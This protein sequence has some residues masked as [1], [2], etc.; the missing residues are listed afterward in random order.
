MRYLTQI[1]AQARQA[2]RTRIAR[3]LHDTT[4]QG[5]HA[6]LLKLETWAA[7]ERIGSHLRQDVT[8][9][10]G[11]VRQ[12]E[13]EA[14][15]RILELRQ[16]EAPIGGLIEDLQSIAQ[17]AQKESPAKYCVETR[18][19][20][21]ALKPEAYNTLLD[22]A[23]EAVRNARRHSGATLVEVQLAFYP[24][25]VRL[26]VVDNGQGL[27]AISRE[28]LLASGRFGLL[29]MQERAAELGALL[30]VESAA[31]CGCRVELR[32]PAELA[33]SASTPRVGWF[34]RARTAVQ[35]CLRERHPPTLLIWG[36]QD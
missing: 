12:I 10:L 5:I 29:G 25:E 35:V 23:R 9:V 32:V 19:M 33:F 27:R 13:T 14:R 3:D 20:P 24:K 30:S 22:V 6:V 15:A 21:R 16:R 11:E 36:K 26:R 31:G 17:V 8:D 18:G 34:Q 1:G 4:L 28:L 2:E 7:D